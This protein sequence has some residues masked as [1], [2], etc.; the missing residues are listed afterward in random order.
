MND[1]FQDLRTFVAVVQ[2]RG[3]AT[4]ADRLGLVKSA[5]SRRVR[6][7]EERLG[8]RLLQRTTRSI[9][10]T[11][12]GGEF[13][14]RAVR[15]LADLDEAETMAASGTQ[16]A[17][18]KLKVTA[19]VALVSRCLAATAGD[20]L[21][22]HPRLVVELHADDGLVDMVAGGYDLA[23]RT[24]ELRDSSLVA[25]RVS[26]LGY[27]N[28]ASPAYL[29]AHGSPSS[30]EELR[31]HRRIVHANVDAGREQHARAGQPG[32]ARL[33]LDNEEAMR[34]AVL[35]GGGVAT[36]PDILVRADVASGALVSLSRTLP[37][38]ARTVHALFPSNRNVPAKTRSFIEFVTEGLEETRRSL[39]VSR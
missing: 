27:V 10:L 37:C 25:R 24:G 1:R 28:V 21:Q 16:D 32:E 2:G 19:P 4:A 35:A 14:W 38:D 22:R 6:E 29:A 11:D 9:S 8:T 5:V 18:G 39:D 3:F 26:S 30:S 31:A 13:Y 17:S 15:I 34:W 33:I 23:I 12:S 7:L 36:L 20:L